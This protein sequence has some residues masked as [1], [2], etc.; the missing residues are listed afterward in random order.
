MADN[1]AVLLSDTVGFIQDLPHSL[2][3]AFRATL[4]EVTQADLLIHVVDAADRYAEA[5]FE[6]VIKVLAEIGADKIPAVVALNKWDVAEDDPEAHHL[7]VSLP[8]ALPISALTGYNLEELK[9]AVTE[10]LSKRLTPAT[11]HLPYSKLDVLQSVRARGHVLN[12][13]YRPDYVFVEAE[14]DEEM[15]GRLKPYITAEE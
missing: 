1:F 3:A 13:D 7:L 9:M 15:L 4:E 6:A 11:M 8:E 12:E 14:L 5:Q 10:A 2:V